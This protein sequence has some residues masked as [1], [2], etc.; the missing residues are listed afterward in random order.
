MAVH[1]F[2]DSSRRQTLTDVGELEVYLFYISKFQASL[3]YKMRVCVRNKNNKTNWGL[4]QRL[5]S[6]LL[7]CPYIHDYA[8]WWGWGR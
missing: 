5:I 4:R 1:F 7:V 8:S 2:N 6:G 3:G